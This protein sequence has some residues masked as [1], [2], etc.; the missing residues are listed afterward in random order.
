MNIEALLSR[1]ALGQPRLAADTQRPERVYVPRASLDLLYLVHPMMVYPFLLP[2]TVWHTMHAKAN[3]MGT[4]QQVDTLNG[5]AEGG[6]GRASESH[7][8]PQQNE[9][10]QLHSGIEAEDKDMPRP[11]TP[12]STDPNTGG[13]GAADLP[14]AIT[15]PTTRT[16]KAGGDARR[17]VGS[18]PEDP[19]P[20]LQRQN[21]SAAP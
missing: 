11:P 17:A 5:L 9:P 8:R 1:L 12:P 7:R 20:F 2:S 3:A 18:R 4:T 10:C 16:S 19:P 6:N 21:G 13:P 15:R 14:A